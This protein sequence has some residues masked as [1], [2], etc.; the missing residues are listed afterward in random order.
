M[1]L[2]FHKYIHIYLHMYTY[3]Y[4]YLKFDVRGYCS[5]LPLAQRGLRM[6]FAVHEVKLK[7][8]VPSITNIAME[9]HHFKWENSP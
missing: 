2:Y 3:I 8:L 4:V 9:N 5:G 7:L 6:L 1:N